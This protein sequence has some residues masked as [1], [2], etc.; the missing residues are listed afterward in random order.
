VWITVGNE[1]VR[2]A[3]AADYCL[4]WIDQLQQQAEAWPG[5]RSQREKAHVYAQFD[6]ARAIYRQR[7]AEAAAAGRL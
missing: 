1:P 5:W 7:R 2:S 6:E 4:Q 3:A